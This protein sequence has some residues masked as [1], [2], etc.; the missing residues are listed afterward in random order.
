MH[1]MTK[2]EIQTPLGPLQFRAR[3]GDNADL[4]ETAQLFV[5]NPLL[6]LPEGMT[7]ER[8]TAVILEV[9]PN[10][11][12]APFVFECLW[13]TSPG[14]WGPNSGQYLDAW[15]WEN[16]E[17][18][19]TI[20]TEDLEA[21]CSRLPQLALSA[22]EYPIQ[23]FDNGVRITI[24]V[25]EAGQKFSL[26]FVVAYNSLPQPDPF[27]CSTWFAVDIP[28]RQLLAALASQNAYQS[29]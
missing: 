6:R 24:P 19:V 16:T 26:H 5:L 11:R 7:V 18:V 22:E 8:A 15:S 13:L 4:G 12:W 3:A 25:V 1:F 28:H 27:D 29:T 23:S 17:H 20:G 10:R 9:R 2:T 14:E 21:V